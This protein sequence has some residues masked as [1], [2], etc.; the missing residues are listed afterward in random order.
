MS[1]KVNLINLRKKSEQLS[2]ELPVEEI[3]LE[4]C[5]E[6]IAFKQPV[7][8][9]LTAEWLDKSVLVQ[10]GVEAPIDCECV[11]CL[12]PFVTSVI[13][14]G[15]ALHL[16]VSGEEAVEIID[17][18]V[19]LTPFLR[20]DILLGLPQHPL[21]RSDCEG[22]KQDESEQSETGSKGSVWSELDNL[23]FDNE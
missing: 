4:S 9:D 1:L 15:Y 10:G 13:L 3:G 17:D 14:T 23:K 11:R 7:E 5:D 21:C 18:C 12:Q 20:E 22:L 16:P 19:D 8:Y 6:M 2:G